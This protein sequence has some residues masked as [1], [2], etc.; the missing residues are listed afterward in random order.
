M[1]W[2][3]PTAPPPSDLSH[4]N[5]EAFKNRCWVLIK[6]DRTREALA[7]CNRALSLLP[8]SASIPPGNG[9]ALR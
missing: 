3:S 2:R 6:V 1:T 4:T 9:L 7:D 8:H 5:P